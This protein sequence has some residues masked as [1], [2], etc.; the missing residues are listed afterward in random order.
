MDSINE[1]MSASSR[2]S[3]IQEDTYFRLLR[4]LEENPDLSQREIARQLGLSLGGLN[5]CLRALMHK[6]FVK[7][8]NFQNSRHKFRYIY[9]LTPEGI[10]QRIAMTGRFLKRKLE[11]YDSLRAEIEELK[12]EQG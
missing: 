7:L 9:V 11:E 2:Q 6:G 12:R 8:G 4:L 5:Y 3:R 1:T 10:A